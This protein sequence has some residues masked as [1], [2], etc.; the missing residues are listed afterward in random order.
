MLDDHGLAG[1]LTALR[2][3]TWAHQDPKIRFLRER[4]NDTIATVA[5]HPEYAKR[6]RA[7]SEAGQLAGRCLHWNGAAWV[8][9][10]EAAY[11]TDSG[12]GAVLRPDDVMQGRPDAECRRV[13]QAEHEQI[14][15]RVQLANG[16]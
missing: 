6:W 2:W 4:G 15:K 5:A 16:W 7:W 14:W 8:A 10:S 3:L 12:T 11:E 9:P 13:T 1:T